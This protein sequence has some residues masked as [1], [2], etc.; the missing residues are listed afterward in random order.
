MKQVEVAFILAAGRGERLRPLTDSTPKP[1]LPYKNK[2]LLDHIL[3]SLAPLHL[4]RIVFNAWHL[5][6]QVIAYAESKRKTLKAEI[7]VSS[8]SELLGTAGGLKKA[9]SLINSPEFLMLNGDCLWT[10]NI[11]EFA[12]RASKAP[13]G[14]WWLTQAEENQTQIGVYRSNICQIGSLLKTAEPE[15]LGCF[16]GIQWIKNLNPQDLPDKGCIVRQY[17]VP[18]IQRQPTSLRGDFDGLNSWIDIGTTERY[19]SLA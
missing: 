6:E 10:G 16:T 11:A 1:L 14:T 7:L 2:P 17:F 9:W 18:L 8:E 3:D 15:T 5:K 13:G 12:D 4:K 19:R